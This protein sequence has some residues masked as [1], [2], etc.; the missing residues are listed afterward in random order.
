MRRTT[1][2]ILT[3]GSWSQ[4]RDQNWATGWCTKK[5]RL[6]TAVILDN[7]RTSAGPC[8]NQL[9]GP[10][11]DTAALPSR[12]GQCGGAKVPLWCHRRSTKATHTKAKAVPR[13]CYTISRSKHQS[14]HNISHMVPPQPAPLLCQDTHATSNRWRLS[15]DTRMYTVETTSVGPRVACWGHSRFVALALAVTQQTVAAERLRRH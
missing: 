2:N 6:G 11:G 1:L 15:I 13:S 4:A 7:H 5:A 10:S 12:C 8:V 9:Q 3:D 14:S